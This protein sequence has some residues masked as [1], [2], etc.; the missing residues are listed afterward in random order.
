MRSKVAWAIV[1][2]LVLLRFVAQASA[3]PPQTS[4]APAPSSPA[5]SFDPFDAIPSPS[6]WP[7][8]VAA[9]VCPPTLVG[10]LTRPVGQLRKHQTVVL[11]QEAGDQWLALL[12]LRPNGSKGWIPSSSLKVSETTW[13][14]VV[15]RSA[16][17]LTILH[18][19][20]AVRSFPVAVGKPTTP[21]PKGTFY[22]DALYRLPAGSF[23]GPYS[24]TLSGHS[25]VLFHFDGGEG[26]LGLHGTSDPSSIGQAASHGCVR[27]FNKDIRW[28][29]PRLPLGTI[30]VVR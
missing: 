19:C 27:M 30:V 18:D 11:L 10:T 2:G 25:N 6:P 8:P 24:Y 13:K 16:R 21:T 28:L 22:L 14:L 20:A 7:S 29:V 3:K 26:R 5:S 9:D 12:P 15:D 23:L 1:I 4:P 17:R